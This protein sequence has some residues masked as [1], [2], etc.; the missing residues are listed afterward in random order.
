MRGAIGNDRCLVR[1]KAATYRQRVL[2]TLVIVLL[3][4][5]GCTSSAS[6]SSP[7]SSDAASAHALEQDFTQVVHMTLPS[8]VEIV[9]PSG[10]GSGVIFDGKGHVV[11]NAHVVGKS[12]SFEVRS[13]TGTRTYPATLVASTS[14]MTSR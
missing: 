14:P 8:I 10:L 2:A 13:S 3:T 6:D 7:R 1:G 11:T 4:T 5:V 12:A 9:S